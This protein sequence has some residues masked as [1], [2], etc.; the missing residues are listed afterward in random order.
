MHRLVLVLTLLFNQCGMPKSLAPAPPEPGEAPP[1]QVERG[2]FTIEREE[3]EPVTER[4]TRTAERLESELTAPRTERVVLD[5]ALA[6]DARVTRYE[7]REYPRGAAP[8]DM[9]R[10]VL[11][12]DGDS[13]T[14]DDHKR[15]EHVVERF[16]TQR[17]AMPMLVESA[18]MLEQVIRRARLLGSPAEVPVLN[19][20]GT[21][22]TARVT[23]VEIGRV[24]IEMGD[25]AVMATTDGSGRLLAANGDGGLVIRRAPA[26][27]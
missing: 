20:A 12:F 26:A 19:K 25:Q 8:G 18:A 2:T 10:L 11:T 14:W 1:G 6:R 24:R 16:A 22:E 9:D 13:A 4:F 3:Q 23:T 15:G 27:P 5:V 17:G 21:T 7:Q